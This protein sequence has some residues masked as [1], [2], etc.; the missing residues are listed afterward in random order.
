[1]AA[2]AL[3]PPPTLPPHPLTPYALCSAIERRPRV[4]Q[5]LLARSALRRSFVPGADLLLLRDK[6]VLLVV[7]A[8]MDGGYESA[9]KAVNFIGG[10]ASMLRMY[11]AGTL[12]LEEFPDRAF[13]AAGPAPLC[14]GRPLSPAL[15]LS[16][17]R[18]LQA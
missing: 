10:Q 16:H 13:A 3:E 8:K 6:P 15:P 5:Q 11:N 17:T 7:S 2:P 9:Q 1:M 14:T 18:G 4:N 12:A